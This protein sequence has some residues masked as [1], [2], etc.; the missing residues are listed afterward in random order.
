MASMTNRGPT[1]VQ[2]LQAKLLAVKI[3]LQRILDRIDA[4]LQEAKHGSK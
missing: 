3:D 2:T 4:I 1:E